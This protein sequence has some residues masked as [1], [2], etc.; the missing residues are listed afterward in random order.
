M[1]S[2]AECQSETETE[3]EDGGGGG[4]ERGRWG[5]TEGRDHQDVTIV[6]RAEKV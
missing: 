3:G 2:L 5:D 6:T 1:M 4:E